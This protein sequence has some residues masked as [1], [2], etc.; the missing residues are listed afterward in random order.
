[1]A[2]PEAR[3]EFAQAD[4]CSCE[5]ANSA[6]ARSA[7]LDIGSEC[8]RNKTV[9]SMV[10]GEFKESD[11]FFSNGVCFL[12]QEDVDGLEGPRGKKEF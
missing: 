11:G 4:T 2:S 5:Y 10:L 9:P 7:V 12:Y 1:M 3:R 6:L 8:V